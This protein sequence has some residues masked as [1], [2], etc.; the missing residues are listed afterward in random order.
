MTLGA[1]ISAGADI[2]LVM[3]SHETIVSGSRDTSASWVQQMFQSASSPPL[4]EAEVDQVSAGSGRTQPQTSAAP[5]FTGSPS[6]D[7]AVSPQPTQSDRAVA[8]AVGGDHGPLGCP[9]VTVQGIVRFLNQAGTGLEPAAHSQI[10]IHDHQPKFTSESGW[11]TFTFELCIPS[12]IYVDVWA[13]NERFNV[14]HP[15]VLGPTYGLVGMQYYVD[16]VDEWIEVFIDGEEATRAAFYLAREGYAFADWFQEN[17]GFNPPE[18]VDVEMPVN[19]RGVSYASCNFVIEF[20]RIHWIDRWSGW[21]LRHEYGHVLMC[22]AYDGTP[23]RSN[24]HGDSIDNDGDGA[25]DE[26]VHDGID[27]DG[28]NGIDEDLS[29]N[30]NLLSELHE[31]LALNEGWADFV[32]DAYDFDVNGVLRAG[33]NFEALPDERHFEDGPQ[34]FVPENSN[35]FFGD[36]NV[37]DGASVEGSVASVLWDIWD[38]TPNE[39]TNRVDTNA[40]GWM[41]IPG[42]MAPQNTVSD[43]QVEFVGFDVLALPLSTIWI[44]IDIDKPTDIRDFWRHWFSTTDGTPTSFGHDEEVLRIF[45]DHGIADPDGDGVPNNQ[46]PTISMFTLT[47]PLGQSNRV[48]GTLVFQ[49]AVDD[50]DPG[51]AGQVEVRLELS[52]D[53]EDWFVGAIVAGEGTHTIQFDSTALS[54]GT[55]WWRV[56]AHDTILG[57]VNPVPPQTMRT[58]ID[59]TPPVAPAAVETETGGVWSSHSHPRF[60]WTTADTDIEDFQYALDG[61]PPTYKNWLTPADWFIHYGVADGTHTFQVRAIDF[62][63]NIGPWSAS[64]HAYVDTEAPAVI[65]LSHLTAPPSP[66]TPD[67]TDQSDWN[68]PTFAWLVSD[69]A[70]GLGF[71]RFEASSMS[72]VDANGYFSGPI[73]ASRDWSS[74]QGGT[75]PTECVYSSCY[76]ANMP[77]GVVYWH[78]LADD[79][80]GNSNGWAA[81][82]QSGNTIW[83]YENTLIHP[84]TVNDV[85]GVTHAVATVDWTVN[86]VDHDF[87]RYRVSWATPDFASGTTKLGPAMSQTQV[88]YTVDHLVCSTPYEFKVVTYDSIG[89]SRGSSNTLSR[90]TTDQTGSPNAITMSGPVNIG[91][92]GMS[93]LWTTYTAADF[94][95]YE[96]LYSTTS[97]FTSYSSVIIIDQSTGVKHISGLSPD[98]TYYF[99]IRVAST[100]PNHYSSYSTPIISG[101]TSGSYTGVLDGHVYSV[102]QS[103]PVA[104]ALVEVWLNGAR[105]GVDSTD[106]SGFYRLTGLPTSQALVVTVTKSCYEWDGN[107]V[108][109]QEGQTATRDFVARW[110]CA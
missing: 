33:F 54:D 58:E 14:R 87:W 83:S 78:V 88:S 21:T 73:L 7:G 70:S 15:G 47:T 96:L 38:D 52:T 74:S 110:E 53:L 6:P 105:V 28:N 8:A 27:D 98:T 3:D 60:E 65:L 91:S 85:S 31:R 42:V 2:G 106:S 17:T 44:V 51:D 40:D 16:Q 100:C 25:I 56:V 11:F 18:S 62:A 10:V 81:N 66:E 107:S 12:T 94:R 61:G 37:W 109:I 30:H 22:W 26:E 24:I 104:G 19:D 71:L 48:G 103:A 90:T 108:T 32:A 29:N 45:F 59:N 39:G 92:A 95:Q 4:E 55:Y 86:S 50:P 68:R 41:Y 80:A 46:A 1:L 69:A 76:P 57:T 97:G 23:P 102:G 36:W 93:V 72:Q 77:K 99:K 82:G 63:G 64:V 20:I 43:V 35:P 89:D 49:V 67:P 13:K 5:G 9:L 75:A 101:T 84:S 34:G 79:M